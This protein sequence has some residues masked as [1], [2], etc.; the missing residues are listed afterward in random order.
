MRV[1]L[2]AVTVG[3]GYRVS[4]RML[5]LLRFRNGGTRTIY[6]GVCHCRGSTSN[7]Q[8][9]TRSQEDVTARLAIKNGDAHKVQ[10]GGND[11]EAATR[12]Q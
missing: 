10:A 8:L 7:A 6:A 1:L 4:Q 3:A 9:L 2:Y 5:A 12:A 11:S